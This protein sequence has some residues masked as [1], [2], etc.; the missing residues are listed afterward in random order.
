[1][2]VS[3]F[4]SILFL[5][6]V[7]WSLGAS[8]ITFNIVGGTV[9][10]F[11]TYRVYVLSGEWWLA[12][13]FWTLQLFMMGIVP[14]IVALSIK[15]GGLLQFK[16]RYDWLVYTCLITATIVSFSCHLHG[17]TRINRKCSRLTW[18]TPYYFVGFSG[19]WTAGH[20]EPTRL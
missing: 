9:E 20:I 6:A 2:I 8:L 17:W 13:P 16:D 7:P 5:N 4:G 12:L 1:M 19:A 14:S 15:S 11:F 10:C 18:V 3:N